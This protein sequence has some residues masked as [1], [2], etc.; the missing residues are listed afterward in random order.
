[1]LADHPLSV[2]DSVP[3]PFYIGLIFYRRGLLILVLGMAI[4]D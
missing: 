1:M 3:H 4:F 2:F